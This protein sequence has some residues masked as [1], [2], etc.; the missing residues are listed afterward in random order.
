MQVFDLC[1]VYFHQPDEWEYVRSFA[2]PGTLLGVWYGRY[3]FREDE[4]YMRFFPWR[5]L[6]NGHNSIWWYAVY[7]GLS[8]CPMDA[9]TPSMALYPYFE[10]TADEIR[11]ING[12]IMYMQ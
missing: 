11:Q 8:V 10:D 9:M 3:S 4:N 1:N 6:L 2:R 12:P 7:H 5:V